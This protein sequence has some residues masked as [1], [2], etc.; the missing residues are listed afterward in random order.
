MKDLYVHSVTLCLSDF[1]EVRTKSEEPLYPFS[2]FQIHSLSMCTSTIAI[3][4]QSVNL[5][6][7]ILSY[8]SNLLFFPFLFSLLF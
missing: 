8:S 1:C 3:F 2:F 4:S 7:R 6:S 5:S